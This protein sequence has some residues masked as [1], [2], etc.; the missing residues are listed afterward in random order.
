MLLSE[1]LVWSSLCG[2]RT[3][4]W[5]WCRD[6]LGSQARATGALCVKGFTEICSSI[7]LKNRLLS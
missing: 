6:S 1:V 7:T 3:Q 4:W 5:A 2:H